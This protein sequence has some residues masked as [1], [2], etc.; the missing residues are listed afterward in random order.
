MPSTPIATL[1]TPETVES[2]APAMLHIGATLAPD[3]RT[4]GRTTEFL[5]KVIFMTKFVSNRKKL[6]YD[7][8]QY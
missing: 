1:I 2:E 3:A 8:P 5:L 7:P 4:H 6:C